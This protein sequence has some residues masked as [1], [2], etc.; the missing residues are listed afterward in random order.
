[1][2]KRELGGKGNRVRAYDNCGVPNIGVHTMKGRW[3]TKAARTYY[4]Y[5]RDV[6]SNDLL[7]AKYSPGILEFLLFA[8]L[9]SKNGRRG[10]GGLDRGDLG[11]YQVCCC[12]EDR[13]LRP[14][15]AARFLNPRDLL[16]LSLPQF[17]VEAKRCV[18]MPFL[19][20]VVW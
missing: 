9:P 18:S 4:H 2:S 8:P 17:A 13:R 1:M 12:N 7:G 15:L 16:S 14:S 3:V 19:G 10:Q 5:P 6:A 20:Y 11:S